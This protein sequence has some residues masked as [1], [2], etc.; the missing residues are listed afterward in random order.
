MRCT[1][2]GSSVTLRTNPELAKAAGRTCA[3]PATFG[4]LPCATGIPAATRQ[5]FEA[6]RHGACRKPMSVRDVLGRRAGRRV[7][8][9]FRHAKGML[10]DEV[11]PPKEAGPRLSLLFGAFL[12]GR[13]W[14]LVATIAWR[15]WQRLASVSRSRVA[16]C[17]RR[18]PR[19]LGTRRW[20]LAGGERDRER[21]REH[22]VDKAHHGSS[23]RR[24]RATPTTSHGGAVPQLRVFTT[25]PGSSIQR[26]GEV[27][28]RTKSVRP[29]TSSRRRR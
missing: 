8:V 20:W 15:G 4:G 2:S 3:K 5:A 16:R 21:R 1:G 13:I 12:H 19:T 22:H 10:L 17:H 6:R 27:G 11:Q 24:G 26:A 28:K 23:H 25:S 29:E 14:P 7:T 9:G 18:R